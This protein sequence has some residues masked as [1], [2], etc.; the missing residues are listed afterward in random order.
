[1]RKNTTW[2]STIIWRNNWRYIIWW[3]RRTQLIIF[4]VDLLVFVKTIIFVIAILQSFWLHCDFCRYFYCTRIQYFEFSYC[5]FFFLHL[6]Q[7]HLR[8]IWMNSRW[9][10]D[11]FRF[12]VL[13]QPFYKD[14]SCMLG[15][16]I[17]I[18]A[19]CIDCKFVLKSCNEFIR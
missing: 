10:Q 11:I 8:V 4:F 5:Y 7:S 13:T 15:C 12:M 14:Q 6:Y 16:F 9:S 1:M 19:M 18:A 3:S 17:W 2:K